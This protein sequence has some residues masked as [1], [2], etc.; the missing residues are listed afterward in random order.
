MNNKKKLFV[1]VYSH[2]KPMTAC[3]LTEEGEMIAS[4]VDID[5]DKAKEALFKENP[6]FDQEYEV[7]VQDQET[8]ERHMYKG[9]SRDLVPKD[10]Q[11]AWDRY[12]GVEPN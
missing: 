12:K 2:T 3:A 8:L 4:A 6:T 1:W 9:E 7:K 5:R 10:F 11:I